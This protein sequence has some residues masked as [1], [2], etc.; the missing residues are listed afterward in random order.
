MVVYQ[1]TVF[2]NTLEFCKKW[3]WNSLHL[4]VFCTQSDVESQV[5]E[6]G[7]M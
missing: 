4:E 3:W 1:G 2:L 6:T 5:Q 7:I